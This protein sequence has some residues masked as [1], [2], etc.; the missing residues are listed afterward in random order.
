MDDS[1]RTPD[2]HGNGVADATTKFP[3][4]LYCRFGVWKFHTYGCIGFYTNML[5]RSVIVL[6]SSSLMH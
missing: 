1:F 2:I 4:Q 5:Y 6:K 3:V